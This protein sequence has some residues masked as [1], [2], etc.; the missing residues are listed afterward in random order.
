MSLSYLNRNNAPSLAYRKQDG[1]DT[2]L[3]TVLFLG[4]FRSD[5]EGTKA[6]FLANFCAKRNQS[7]V[8]FDYRGHGASEG[9]F[10]DATIGDWK[11]DSLDVLEQIT[12][13]PVLLIGSSMGGWLSLLIARDAPER[14]CGLIGLAPAPDF[15]R[16]VLDELDEAQKKEM[17]DQGLCKIPN[18]YG[19]D[20]IFTRALIEEGEQHCMLD[21]PIKID[22]PTRLIQG[23]QD[24]DVPWQKAHRINNALTSQDKK[25]YLLE[26]GDH[27][28]SRP[29]DLDL[30]GKLVD[31][32]S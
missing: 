32:L 4:G 31:E 6:Q 5:M 7:Y 11:Q 30:L 14:L 28:L 3:P 27:R 26:D 12:S 24:T 20:Y 25:V 15:T 16:E 23:M 13:G 18:D 10:E 21:D 17:M 19:A 8:R 2:S 22:I 9:R 1:A 29:Q